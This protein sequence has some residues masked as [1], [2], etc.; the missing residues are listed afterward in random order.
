MGKII[1]TVFLLLTCIYAEGKGSQSDTL[2]AQ[3]LK[4]HQEQQIPD[5]LI[6]RRYMMTYSTNRRMEE[7]ILTYLKAPEASR[8][9]MPKPF[10]LKFPMKETL[11]MDKDV[12]RRY[13]RAYLEKYDLKKKLV[14]EK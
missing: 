6:Y 2:E 12:L 9:I 11:H 14:L 1:L 4:C 13:V 10:F 3:C 7:A 8:S 5:S